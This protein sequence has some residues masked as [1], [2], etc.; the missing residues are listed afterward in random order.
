MLIPFNLHINIRNLN[1]VNV[2]PLAFQV[3]Y[4]GLG[5][6]LVALAIAI[7]TLIADKVAHG[8]VSR[9]VLALQLF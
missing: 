3:G 8:P 4:V 1:H 9:R 2:N 6:A 5:E 7:L